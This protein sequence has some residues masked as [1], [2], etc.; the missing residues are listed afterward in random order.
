MINKALSGTLKG[1][2]LLSMGI[3]IVKLLS[4]FYIPFLSR[5]LGPE[6]YGTLTIATIM[7]PWFVMLSTLSL[8]TVATKLI[9]EHNYNKEI[10]GSIIK[11]L[12]LIGLI[13][14]IIFGL[15]HFL[16]AGF[17]AK[18]F[19]HDISI[20]PYFQISSIVILL[21]V[22]YNI[23]IGIK[24]GQKQ[25]MTYTVLEIIK[26]A[27]LVLTG[28]VL[29]ILFTDDIFSAIIATILSFG[30]IVFLYLVR[31][32]QYF[33]YKLFNFSKILKHS[34]NITSFSLLITI[35]TTLDKFILGYLS[36]KTIVGV[37]AI[38]TAFINFGLIGSSSF[39]NAY[40]PYISELIVEKEKKKKEISESLEKLLIYSTLVLGI[41]V[42]LITT[43]RNYFV[44]ILFG[45]EFMMAG[46]ILI[47]SIYTI[48]FMNIFGIIHVFSLALEKYKLI[49]KI[50]IAMLVI[51]LIITY[52]LTKLFGMYGTAASLLISH[53]ILTSLYFKFIVNF[54]KINLKKLYLLIFIVF[55]L[56]LIT[57]FINKEL[58][59]QIII[60]IF[61]IIVY[62]L[63]TYKFKYYNKENIIIVYSF[64]KNK[65]KTMFQ[66]NYN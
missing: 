25:F 16:A 43:L 19:F 13:L 64:L 2:F 4:V 37:Y 24:R 40:F 1:A 41:F 51:S 59:W 49:Y 47:I 36:S 34:Y 42:I 61:S 7:I 53:I 9:S 32:I 55:T 3:M 44:K 22:L 26:Q 23:I 54:A 56:G 52:G 38:S 28:V 57:S 65:I 11:T 48:L 62:L 21:S 46:N 6:S 33:K 66:K 35:L 10:C 45:T 15:V 30:V 14:G 31:Y 27:I 50:S 12:I 58:K 60:F 5:I 20:K 29:I 63:L 8:S 39:K 18:V 17:I